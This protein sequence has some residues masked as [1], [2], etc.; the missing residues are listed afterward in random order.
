MTTSIVLN[1]LSS[2]GDTTAL[3]CDQGKMSYKALREAVSYMAQLLNGTQTAAIMMENGPAWVIV[4]LA[5]IAAQVPLVPLPE[6]FSRQQIVH[7]LR[8]AGVDTVFTDHPYRFEGTCERHSVADLSFYSIKLRRQPVSLPEGTAKITYTSGTTGEPKGVCLTQKAM[9]TVAASLIE[10]IGQGTASDHLCV[11]PL[12]ILLENVAGVYPVLMTGASVCLAPIKHNPVH[13]VEMITRFEATSCILVPELLRMLL[14][15]GR[16]LPSLNYVAVGGAHVPRELVLAAHG[17]KIPVYEGYG[18]SEASSVVSVNTPA[19]SKVGSVG[20]SLR[21]IDLRFGDDGEILVKNPL[22]SGYLNAPSSGDVWYPTGDIGRIDD[23]GFLY[24]DG[25]K[26]NIF[27]TSF[28]RNISPE[29]IEGLLTTQKEILQ[30]L[31]YGE[32]RPSNIAIIVTRNPA[33]LSDVIDR[34]NSQ[35]PD[36][37]RIKSWICAPEPFSLENGH[38][39]GTGRLR[40]EKIQETYMPTIEQHY[41]QERMTA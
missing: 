13:L 1:S 38:L 30:A 28:G 14:A 20:K 34:V 33:N 39:T 2:Y 32:A 6:F 7:A 36:Y 23:E 16:P 18:L 15:V 12:A 27:I 3:K 21:H 24:V 5:C 9:E 29:W 17:L 31:V 8:D 19:V 35:L 22:F 41:A 11:L 10:R 4:D 26:K 25:R 40:R 37:A